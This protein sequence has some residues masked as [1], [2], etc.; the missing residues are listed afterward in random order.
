MKAFSQ[1]ADYTNADRPSSPKAS[2]VQPKLQI[3]DPGDHYEKEADA[4]AD[5]VMRMENPLIKPLPI[6]GVQRKCADCK[7]EENKVQRKETNASEQNQD[8]SLD[9]YISGVSGGQSLPNELRNFYEPR[10]GYNFR[11]AK[12]HTDSAAAKSA[13]SI[14]ALAYTTGNDIVFNNGQ[15][16]PDSTKGRQLLAH[17]L[18]HVVQQSSSTSSPQIQRAVFENNFPGGGRVDTPMTGEH[19]FW[20]FDVGKSKLKPEHL[21]KIPELAQ[22]IKDSLDLK[23]DQEQVD[24]EG[25]ASSTGTAARNDA[26]ASSRAEAIKQALISEGIPAKQIRVTVVG[27]SKSEAGATQE[28]FARSRAVRVIMVPRTKMTKPPTP[29]REQGCKPGTKDNELLPMTIDGTSVNFGQEGPFMVLRAGT[30]SKPGIE[31]SALPIMTPAGCGEMSFIQNVMAFI[32]I[33]YKDGSRNT[34]QTPGFM[35]DGGDPYHC[36]FRD[37]AFVADDGPSFGVSKLQEPDVNTMEV[38]EDFRTFL[39]FQPKDGTRKT[40]QVAEWRW[41]GQAK[42]DD[43]ENKKAPVTLDSSISRITPTFGKGFLTREAPLLNPFIG[44]ALFTTDFNANP[45][46]DSL[47]ARLVDALNRARP[48][49]KNGNVCSF[50]VTGPKD[51]EKQSA[52]AKRKKT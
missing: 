22:E 52:A 12:L 33:I 1:I 30:T 37:G 5:K 31:V 49:R 50:K 15:Y 51:L 8:S 16:N 3:N 18:T 14:N 7:E 34:L 29:Q 47:A 6:T 24:I 23:N 10:F 13:S 46:K 39:M 26:L 27:E 40:H 25:Q 36:F 45:S 21:K 17:E 32:Q 4:V 19:R 43:P 41:V 28:S 35:L 48:K 2:L 11:N 44:D 9:G 42:K 38:R 20:N